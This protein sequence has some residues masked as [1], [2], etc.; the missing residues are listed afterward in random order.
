MSFLLEQY[1]E[2]KVARAEKLQDG[3]KRLTRF[4]SFKQNSEFPAEMG[5]NYGDVDAFSSPPS[6]WSN[7]RLAKIEADSTP[8]NN[9]AGNEPVIVLTYEEP[10]TVKQVDETRNNGGLLLRTITSFY[11]TPST[12]SG[13][14]LV[15]TSTDNLNGYAYKTYTFAKGAGEVSRFID[16]G[17]SDDQ[18]T[19]GVTKTTIRYLVVPGASVQPTSL[20]GSVEIGR[21]M[22]E[23]DGYRIWSTTWAKGTG[24]VAVEIGARQDGLREVTNVSLGSRSAP[25]GIVIRDDYREA[26]G[27]TIYTVTA[28]QAKDGNADPTTASVSFERYVPF[29]YP[30]RAKAWVETVGSQDFLDVFLS[31]PVTTL[32]KST[33]TVSY[34][35]TS[36]LGTISDFWNPSTFATMRA[37]WVGAYGVAAS[38]NQPYPGYRTVSSTP[39]TLTGTGYNK[40]IFG[41]N[42]YNGTTATVTVT[43]GPS[44]PGG[45]TWTLSA[46]IE[47]AFTS[48]TGTVYYRKTLIS[49]AV[50]SQA[51]LPV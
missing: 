10:G 8:A 16:Y 22:E 15:D 48:S 45:S 1:R 46:E 21:N 37:Q 33:V 43:G 23:G 12:P 41:F 31:P 38:R 3:R 20:S 27:Y 2:I 25:S 36:T 6:G 26:D 40:A 18:G 49:C 34:T 42:I 24:L 30:G 13:Y 14:T 50:P 4:I 11:D 9:G 19:T 47:P 35:T 5:I 44:D 32:L 51:S 7:L 29:T 17:Q 39:V 28:M